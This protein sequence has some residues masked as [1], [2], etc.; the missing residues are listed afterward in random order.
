MARYPEY[1]F[2]ASLSTSF[3]MAIIVRF[4]GFRLEFFPPMRVAQ[5]DAS[6]FKVLMFNGIAPCSESITTFLR[7]LIL[8]A[9]CTQPLIITNDFICAFF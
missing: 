5:R 1:A 2:T 6:K 8:A 3:G 4:F 9:A 7:Y